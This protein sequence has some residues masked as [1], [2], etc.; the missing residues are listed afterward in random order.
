MIEIEILSPDQNVWARSMALIEDPHVVKL[1]MLSSQIQ[2]NYAMPGKNKSTPGAARKRKLANN[3]QHSSRWGWV[4]WGVSVC[5]RE[6]AKYDTGRGVS[7]KN[8]WLFEQN[9]A[10]I[11]QRVLAVT[12]YRALAVTIYKQGAYQLGP[13][14]W[15]KWWP[16]MRVFHEKRLSTHTDHLPLSLFL[17]ERKHQTY[18]CFF[19]FMGAVWWPVGEVNRENYE[20]PLGEHSW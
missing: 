1:V 5:V 2:N 3:N 11:F 14:E 16:V 6:E 9:V 20:G 13:L 17:A 19:L 4:R 8:M 12:I 10:Q 7:S 18:T 15:G